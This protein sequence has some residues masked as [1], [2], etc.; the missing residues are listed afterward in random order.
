MSYVP[1]PPQEFTAIASYKN[2][3][4][5]HMIKT[6]TLPFDADTLRNNDLDD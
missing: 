1:T 3:L 2:I 6:T 4:P 5:T